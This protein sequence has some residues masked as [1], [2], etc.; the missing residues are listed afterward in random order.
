MFKKEKK[1]S[2]KTIVVYWSSASGF[3]KQDYAALFS[4]E[5]VPIVKT[6]P[7]RDDEFDHNI[8]FISCRA[9]LNLFKNTYVI[10][11]P[12]TSTAKL[13]NTDKMVPDCDD[14]G[15]GYWSPMEKPFENR[16]R[17]DLGFG[18]IFFAE[19]DLEIKMLPP[20]MHKVKSAE[21]SWV[22]PGAYNIGKWFRPM[23][24]SYMLWENETEVSIVKDEP[25]F[26]VQFDTNKKVILKRF[27]FTNEMQHL[28]NELMWLRDRNSIASLE[29]LYS[30]FI[31]SFRHKKVL[32]L[33]KDNLL[34]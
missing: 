30:V 29:F 1:D 12:V 13:Y 21:T 15:M 32:K 23:I 16:L 5:P 17:V 19:E 8:G 20:F 26:Y 2:S 27:E 34:E 3:N 25:S 31:K 14:G 9:M 11:N 7:Q 4:H 22:A 28:I 18:Y 10:N 24:P 33:I 6:L